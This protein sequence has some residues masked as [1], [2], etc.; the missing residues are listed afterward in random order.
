MPVY[1]CSPRTHTSGRALLVRESTFD[2]DDEGWYIQGEVHSYET[3]KLLI[4]PIGP[5]EANWEPA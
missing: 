3:V 5:Q 2:E 4:N 1:R